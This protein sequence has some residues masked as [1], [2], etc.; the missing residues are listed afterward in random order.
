MN[1]CS[2]LEP[3]PK[4][5]GANGSPLIALPCTVPKVPQAK[6]GQEA[7]R[8]VAKLPAPETPQEKITV[9]E[10]TGTQEQ[11]AQIMPAPIPQEKTQKEEGSPRGKERGKKD[12]ELSVRERKA[13]ALLLMGHSRKDA[14]ILAGYSENTATHNPAVI[15]GK[16]VVLRALMKAFEDAGISVTK[17]AKKQLQ[18]LEAKKVV[19]AVVLGSPDANGKTIDFVEVPDNQTQVKALELAYKVRGDF[20]PEV[21]AVVTESY[22]DRI[23]RLRGIK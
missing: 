19:S 9:P 11:T 6:P 2:P 23:K 3:E 14:L 17:L 20:A 10:T 18:L 16:P 7:G 4:Q 12:R 15:L 21:H 1:I 5:A 22:A 13:V 8:E